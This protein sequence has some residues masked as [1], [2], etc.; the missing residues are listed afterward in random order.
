MRTKRTIACLAAA[1]LVATVHAEVGVHD[2]ATCRAITDAAVRL[3]CYDK[4]FAADATATAQIAAPAATAPPTIAAE[5]GT[6]FGYRGNAA[7]TAAPDEPKSLSFVVE[8]VDQ[9]PDSEFIVT[10]ENGQVWQQVELNTR[11]ELHHGDRVVIRKA[12]L[13]SFLLT[14]PNGLSTHVKRIR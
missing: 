6:H 12:A 2:A 7:A 4:L 3:E 10:F 11:I 14:A 9:R 13:S 8:R 1:L 5:P